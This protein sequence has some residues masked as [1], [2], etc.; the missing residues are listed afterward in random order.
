MVSGCMADGRIGIAA[1]PGQ[2]GGADD[3]LHNDAGQ[4]PECPYDVHE[5]TTFCPYKWE[6]PE[7]DQVGT[8]S[9]AHRL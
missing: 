5:N 3:V 1:A 7:V 9:P 4:A 2:D 6:F 8:K